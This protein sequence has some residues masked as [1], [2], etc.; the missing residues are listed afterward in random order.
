MTLFA[1]N[2]T[3]WTSDADLERMFGPFGRQWVWSIRRA[4]AW[5]QEGLS[6]APSIRTAGIRNLEFGI[7]KISGKS[8]GW[9]TFDAKDD[10]TAESLIQQFHRHAGVQSTAHACLGPLLPEPAPETP[11]PTPVP[12][13]QM[14]QG[15]KILICPATE[16]AI[17]DMITR[18]GLI[19][20]INDYREA[21][22]GQQ[23]IARRQ[24]PPPMMRDGPPRGLQQPPPPMMPRE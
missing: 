9:C 20:H 6:H 8:R 23:S 1:G 18:D 7:D 15:R 13:R 17:R 21:F 24:P 4:L 5:R 19:G 11:A 16:P 14:V 2:M 22:E 3:W 10:A 12:R